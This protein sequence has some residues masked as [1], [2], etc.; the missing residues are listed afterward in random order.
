MNKFRKIKIKIAELVFLKYGKKIKYF[1]GKNEIEEFQ[2]IKDKEKVILTLTPN[3]GNLG[4]H[5]IAYASQ[6]FIKDNFSDYEFIE[7]DMNEIYEK[8]KALKN[9]LGKDDIIMILGG[10]N[11]GDMYKH[12]ELTR[13]F[14]IKTFKDI[15]IISLPQ[16]ICFSETI[17]GKKELENTKKIYNKN[18]N[19]KL[20]ARE[21]VSF[22][23]MKECFGEDRVGFYPD[24]VLSLNKRSLVS[25]RDGILMCLRSDKEGIFNSDFKENLKSELEKKYS[26]VS[27]SDTVI[28]KNV[29]KF[30]RN[31]EL[32]KI[33]REISASEV[34]ITDRLHGMIFCA[35]TNTPCIVLKT[36]NHKV[37]Q[38]YKWLEKQENI[39]LADNNNINKLVE[40]VKIIRGK[41]S[42]INF[43]NEFN[44][45]KKYIL[46][47]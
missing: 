38:A 12:E 23:I 28:N 22:E 7:L 8:G 13:R 43:S 2:R 15:K 44:D 32:D 27:L 19:L 11:M 35:I 39:I 47:D 5:A 14:I 20:I 10:G 18:K 30:S 42:Y 40:L 1:N 26:K 3:H 37:I 6:K 29:N 9:V 25:N 41:E 33:W 21:K 24:M 36:Y 17:K 45:M 31:E 34:V 46:A 16:T 4:D